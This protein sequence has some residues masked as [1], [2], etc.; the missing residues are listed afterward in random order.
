MLNKK[1]KIHFFFNIKLQCISSGNLILSD[2]ISYKRSRIKYIEITI[3]L[4]L[5]NDIK[6]AKFNTTHINVIIVEI[7]IN[8]KIVDA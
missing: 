3:V 2:S 6:L 8:Q 7:A 4:V 1:V 5:C